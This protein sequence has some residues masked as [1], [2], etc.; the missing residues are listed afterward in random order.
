MDD[1]GGS[2]R[3]F[4]IKAGSELMQ[5]ITRKTRLRTVEVEQTVVTC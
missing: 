4:K 2:D 5:I 1:G 3:P